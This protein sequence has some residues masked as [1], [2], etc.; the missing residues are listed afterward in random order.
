MKHLSSISLIETVTQGPMWNCHA[1]DGPPYSWSGRT[2]HGAMD[3]PAGPCVAPYMVPLLILHELCSS[4]KCLRSQLSYSPSREY[5][6]CVQR[7]LC[8]SVDSGCGLVGQSLHFCI[9]F[10]GESK[11]IGRAIAPPTLPVPTPIFMYR[12]GETVRYS[13]WDSCV[14]IPSGFYG[15]VKE[16]AP[17]DVYLSGLEPPDVLHS[18]FYVLL[19]LYTTVSPLLYTNVSLHNCYTPVTSTFHVILVGGTIHGCHGWSGRTSY[20]GG[21]S[22]AWQN[23][24]WQELHSIMGFLAGTLHVQYTLISIWDLI[25]F[26]YNS[27]SRPVF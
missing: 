26:S 17:R 19:F 24:S 16:R 1:I 13:K 27:P 15:L 6:S 12:R 25:L 4:H 18:G 9:S 5:D 20:G 2:I 7:Y 23:H 21:P 10:F 11:I 8:R 22:M 3:G 14:R